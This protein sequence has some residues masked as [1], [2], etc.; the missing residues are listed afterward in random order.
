MNTGDIVKMKHYK[1]SYTKYPKCATDYNV[2][3]VAIANRK[4]KLGKIKNLSYMKW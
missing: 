4:W 3:A 1:V 2:E